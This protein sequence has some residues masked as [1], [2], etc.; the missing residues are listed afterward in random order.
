MSWTVVNEPSG[1]VS[2]LE[3]RTLIFSTSATSAPVLITRL[4]GDAEGAAEQIEVVD[5]GRADIDLQGV[6]HIL[7]IDAEE[8][9]LGAVDV[10]IDLRR[11]GLEQREDLRR[12]RTCC[13][14]APSA[15]VRRARNAAA[16]WPARSSTIMR[17]PPAVP[18]PLHRRRQ[19]RDEE[20]VLD[21]GQPFVQLGLDRRRRLPRSWPRVERLEHQKQRAGIGRIGEGGAGEADDIHRMRHA[22]HAARDIE[23]ALLHRRRCATAK[24]QAA[25]E[26]RR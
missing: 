19:H 23:R 17:K 21:L 3:L 20:G 18:M 7:H 9:R 16:P 6:E 2:P 26:P 13:W 5:V 22:G 25:V 15:A 12:R 24:R 14:R 11:R 4:R 10:E 8:L 1:T